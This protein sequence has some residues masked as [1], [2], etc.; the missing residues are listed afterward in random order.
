VET[1]LKR[2]LDLYASFGCETK[3]LKQGEGTA[4][5][6]FAVDGG[7]SVYARF[8]D[9]GKFVEHLIYA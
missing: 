9:A 2:F 4:V 7:P 6:F 1:D 8:D 5:L 3:E